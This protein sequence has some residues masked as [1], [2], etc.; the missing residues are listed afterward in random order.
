MSR[1]RMNNEL[2]EKLKRDVVEKELKLDFQRSDILGQIYKEYE[3]SPQIIIRARFMERLLQEKKIYIDDNVFVGSLAGEFGA[4]YLY[5]EWS[6]DWMKEDN[7]F[8]IPEE[9]QEE[10][11]AVFEY[12]KDRSITKRSSDTYEDIF[13]EDFDK[14][15]T[16]GFIANISL[17]P[18]GVSNS[19]YEKVLKYGLKSIIEEA[20][21]RYHELEVTVENK[22][23]FDFYKAVIIE[24]KAVI[25]YANRYAVLAEE[26]AQKEKDPNRKEE[27]LEIAKICSHVPEYGAENFREALQAHWFLH[28][29]S[30]LEQVGCGYSNG[31]LG[32]VLEPFYQKDKAE[33]KITPEEAVYL[34]KHHF[35]KLN[36]INYY[37]GE[38]Y[39]LIESRDTAQTINIGGYTADGKDATGE[40]DSLILD[41]QF[42]L[43]LPQPPIAL[44]YHDK[45][46][47]EF[48]QKAID[49]VKTGIGMPQFMNA[50]VLVERSLDA[51]ARYG[52]TL[53]DARRTCVYGCVS[54][55]I[56]NKT[57]YLM[58]DVVNVAKAVELALYNGIDPLTGLKV[59]IE[60]GNAEEFSSFEEFYDAF[61]RQ[62]E[63]GILVARHHGKI[64]N[65]LYS[66]FIQLPYRSALTDGCIEK[67]LDIWNGGAQFV[68]TSTNINAGVDA[69]NALLAIRS[70]VFEEKKFTI[71]E[72]K[73]ALDADFEGYDIIQRLCFN[74]PKHGNNVEKDEAVVSRV[75]QD[76]FDFFQEDGDN[77]LGIYGKPDA[78]SKSMHNYFGRQTGALPTGRKSHVALTDGSVSAQPGTDTNGSTALITSAANAV[79]TAAYNSVHLNV[80]LNPDIF[81]SDNGSASVI[82]LID[83]FFRQ[84]G[85]HIQFNCID[86]AVLKDARM[87]PENHRDLVVRVAGFSAFFTRLHEGIQ[88]EIIA[89]TEHEIAV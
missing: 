35:L 9:K 36:D 12:W 67:G 69:A 51:Y 33:G 45:L 43:R 84:G 6:N 34:L 22:A 1:I 78:Y 71:A 74:A 87:H 5:P 30:Q 41:A 8:E 58:G 75:Y 55:A 20:E 11:N 81:H 59:G 62:L 65:M 77:Y 80:K 76:A 15:E 18:A 72:L 64:C 56:P 24:L 25:A 14:Y 29:I 26:L 40:V 32:Q 42:D 13:G 3:G 38:E 46:K 47:P 63:H 7:K 50:D 54:T 48:V 83:S 23:K 60:T 37:Y 2:V 57:A 82:S 49:L 85:N 53:A 88:D 66:D 16:S 10:L 39:E 89:R 31:F 86:A 19:N 28:L 79:D 61:A 44:I 17:S 73:E 4:F 52:A 27:L 21:K 68:A 70:L